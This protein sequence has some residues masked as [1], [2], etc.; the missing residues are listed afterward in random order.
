LLDSVENGSSEA[1]KIR[2]LTEDQ[3]RAV[4][5]DPETVQELSREIIVGIE[6]LKQQDEVDA[7]K[8]NAKFVAEGNGFTY[9]YGGM[10]VYHGGL[11]GYIGNPDP[12]I[13]RAMEYEHTNSP[14]AD[15]RFKCWGVFGS[16]HKTTANTEWA[17][18]RHQNAKQEGSRE[19]GRDGWSLN[20][21]MT[22]NSEDC[23]MIKSTKLIGKLMY[24]PVI[25]TNEGGRGQL[26][27]TTV[28][29][30]GGKFTNGLKLEVHKKYQ[31]FFRGGANIGSETRAISGANLSYCAG[32]FSPGTTYSVVLHNKAIVVVDGS[33]LTWND[34]VFRADLQ[35]AEVIAG[36]LYTGE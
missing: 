3:I 7:N 32:D 19:K 9:V 35:V 27:D 1:D 17:Y 21:F 26:L 24:K 13:M 18:I 11:E 31:I 12:D 6:E 15:H 14:Y 20:D 5:E 36:R 22:N 10:D 29:F 16:D 4:L 8:M 30:E 28:A 25:A 34:S 2:Q 23:V 33:D